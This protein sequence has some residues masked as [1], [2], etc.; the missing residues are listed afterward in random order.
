MDPHNLGSLIR[1]ADGAGV[2]GVVLPSHRAVG[3]NDTVR[4]ISAGAAE[5]M[6]IARVSSLGAALQRAR[7]AG[8]WLVGLDERGGEDVWTSN[9]LVPPVALVLGSEDRGLGKGTRDRCDALVK[10][11]QMGRMASL[12]VSVAGAIVMYEVA[13]RKKADAT[14]L[15]ESE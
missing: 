15:G 14:E 11:P 10:I 1:S 2:D 9:L 8:L 7:D 12:N 6:P 13:R 5:V 3:V 4:R